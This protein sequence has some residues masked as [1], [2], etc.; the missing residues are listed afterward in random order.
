MVSVKIRTTAYW[1]L[2]IVL[3]AGCGN[4]MGD[5]NPSGLDKRPPVEPGSIG[6]EV[7]Q[8]SPD[9][10]ISD[11]HGNDVTLSSIVPTAQGVVL[12]FTMWCTLCKGDMSQMQSSAIPAF[13][14][15]RFYAVDYVSGTVAEAAAAE[16][17]NSA[18]TTGFTVLADT[19]QILSGNSG[20]YKG[21]MGIVVVIDRNGVIR[22]N[23]EYKAARLQSVL[24]TLP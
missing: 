2:F 22:M 13:P 7:G 6:T 15:V 10:T 8:I 14:N 24:L 5:L 19:H 21:T 11:T 23:E 1:M 9:F 20:L 12:Y 3:L 16:A 17:E 18:Y 4:T